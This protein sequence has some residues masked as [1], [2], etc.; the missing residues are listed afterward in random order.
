MS[1][2]EWPHLISGCN[3]HD[4]VEDQSHIYHLVNFSDES[5]TR[6]VL[7]IERTAL[8]NLVQ[9]AWAVLPNELQR[10]LA[11]LGTAS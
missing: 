7:K 11:A 3:I 6:V 2:G 9:K 5:G 8:Y 10:S 4:A 1:T